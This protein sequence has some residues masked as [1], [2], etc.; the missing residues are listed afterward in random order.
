[1]GFYYG[2]RAYYRKDICV[3]DLGGLFS[4][5]LIFGGPYCL[6]FTAGDFLRELSWFRTWLAKP[7]V[8]PAFVTGG[9]CKFFHGTAWK[10]FA[11][12]WRNS[13]DSCVMSLSN[14]AIPFA[15]WPSGVP[16]LTNGNCSTETWSHM[17]CVRL[18][19]LVSVLQCKE[20]LISAIHL[21]DLPQYRG[22]PGWGGGRA[23]PCSLVPNKITNY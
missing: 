5:G 18:L 13:K 20:L 1:M 14:L 6:N 7:P 16:I 21:D 8:W 12:F 22:P 4:G 19:V 3:C 10:W 11:T 17:L 15:K 2:G 23:G 9:F